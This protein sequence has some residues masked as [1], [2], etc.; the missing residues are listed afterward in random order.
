M[1]DIRI[2]FGMIIHEQSPTIFFLNI[3]HIILAGV[4]LQ[5]YPYKVIVVYMRR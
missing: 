2:C 3:A 4:Y 1:L 5:N